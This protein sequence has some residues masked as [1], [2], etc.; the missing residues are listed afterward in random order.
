MQDACCFYLDLLILLP[1]ISHCLYLSYRYSVD[2]TV[3]VRKGKLEDA[4]KIYEIIQD[5]P[6]ESDLITSLKKSRLGSKNSDASSVGAAEK[7]PACMVAEAYDQIVGVIIADHC[8]ADPFVE[9]YDVENFITREMHKLDG[10]VH[11]RLRSFVLNPLFVPQSKAILGE[12]CRLLGSTVLFYPSM[13]WPQSCSTFH[14]LL[15]NPLLFQWKGQPV[16][17][18]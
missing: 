11:T 7:H 2:A 10:S 1:S 14:F 17:M 9:Q 8:D 16:M 5:L 15:T 6:N 18:L 3:T 12:V 13:V 4:A